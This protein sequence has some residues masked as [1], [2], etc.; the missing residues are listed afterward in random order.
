MP[1][2]GGS[3]SFLAMMPLCGRLYTQSGRKRIRKQ[4]M[5]RVVVHP[6]LVINCHPDPELAEGDGPAVGRPQSFLWLRE[7]RRGF[8]CNL[9][10]A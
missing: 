8:T 10:L 6:G 1:N 5:S 9:K 3:G 4:V 2:E 7:P